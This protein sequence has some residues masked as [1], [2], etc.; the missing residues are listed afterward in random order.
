MRMRFDL[1][2]ANLQQVMGWLEAHPSI[3]IVTD[4]KQDN[5]IA[6]QVIADNIIRS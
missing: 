2:Q 1:H 4:L 3:K 5:L 6:L